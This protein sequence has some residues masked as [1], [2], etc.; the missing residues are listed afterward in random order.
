MAKEPEGS[1][2]EIGKVPNILAAETNLSPVYSEPMLNDV[3]FNIQGVTFTLQ[4]L[5]QVF[6]LANLLMIT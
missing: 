3:L 1:G 2:C 4:E 5:S 6:S